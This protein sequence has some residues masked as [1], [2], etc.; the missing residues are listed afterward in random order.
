MIGN[1][2]A[3]FFSTGAAPVPASNYQSISTV[4]VGSGGNSSITFSFIP[5]TYKHLQIRGIVKSATQPRMYMRYNGD[6]GSN[7]EYT[8]HNLYGNGA[9]ALA[10][11]GSN[12]TENWF[13]E[14]GMNNQTNNVNAFI[15]DLLDYS[16][17]NKFKT[18]RSLNGFDENGAGQIFLT[19]GLYRK[20]NAIS[21][22]RLFPSSGTFAEYSSFALYGITGA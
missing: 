18:M 13:Y 9:N 17:T 11:A 22:I 7:S 20:T 4:T 12:Q 21:E 1:Q 15:I 10:T 2:I 3:G 14:N 6:T 8:Y 5:S 16:N 19:S